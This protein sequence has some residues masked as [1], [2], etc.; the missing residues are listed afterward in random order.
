ML[1]IFEFWRNRVNR[2]PATDPLLV[3]QKLLARPEAWNGLE[4][5]EQQQIL[6]LL[7]DHIHAH[8]YPGEDGKIPALPESLRYSNHW[9]DGVRQFQVD[10]ENGRYDPEWLQQAEQA[11]QERAEGAFDDFKE[12]EFEEFWG[13][14]QK[15]DKSLVAGESS[16]VKLG[17]LIENGLVREGDIWKLSRGFG[18]SAP[19]GRKILV[20]KEAKVRWL[21]VIHLATEPSTHQSNESYRLWNCT[22]RL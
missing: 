18:G 4:Q 2:L 5:A 16:Q 8:P 10:L 12:Q 3:Q 1:A 9:R 15:L 21:P 13:Q 20:E 7:P 11:V 6:D 19:R 14:K 22:A 17:T